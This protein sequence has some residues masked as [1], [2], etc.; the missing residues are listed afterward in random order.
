MSLIS[1][2]L[3]LNLGVS[4][5]LFGFKAGSSKPGID[6][7]VLLRARSEMKALSKLEPRISLTDSA[8]LAPINERLKGTHWSQEKISF[9]LVNRRVSGSELQSGEK[10]VSDASLRE[11]TAPDISERNPRAWPF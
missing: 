4:K 7:S 3:E 5:S 9:E 10:R 2:R 8:V 11:R 1:S 6:F